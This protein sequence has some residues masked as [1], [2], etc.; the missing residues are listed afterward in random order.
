[1]AILW[2]SLEQF[3]RQSRTILL[4]LHHKQQ[5]NF[6]HL[7]YIQTKPDS[8]SCRHRRL[9]CVVWTP[10]RYGTHHF[11]DRGDAASI[12]YRNRAEITVLM[13]EQKPFSVWF[14]Y[15]YKSYPVYYEQLVSDM[16]LMIGAQL[17][18]V[19]EIAP[20]SPFPYLNRSPSRYG[21][22]AGAKTFPYSVN[23]AFNKRHS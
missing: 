10:I 21:F 8:I 7:G 14:S 23:I 5:H 13:C 9:C 15:R 12:R 4:F 1:M 19:T 22:R 17:L 2:D 3:H 11:R 18:S 20:K 16:W 6:E